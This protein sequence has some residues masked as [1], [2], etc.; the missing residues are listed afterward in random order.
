MSEWMNID[1]WQRCLELQKPGIVFE[2]RN[3]DGQTMMTRC[4]PTVPAMP[5]DWKSGPT[6]FRAIVE[7]PPPHSTPIPRPNEQQ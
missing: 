5:F 3:A 7:A 4:T 2:L 6:Q 1:D